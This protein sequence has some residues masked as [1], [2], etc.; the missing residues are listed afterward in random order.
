MVYTSYIVKRTQ[1][2]LDETQERRL[3]GRASAAGVTKSRL[4]REAVDAYLDGPEDQARQLEAFRAAVQELAKD[5][6][7]LP[8]GRTYV[9]Q[10]RAADVRRQQELDRRRA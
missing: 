5:P 2:Y 1:I 7:D 8:D 3:A 6:L 9:E 4:I 10:L